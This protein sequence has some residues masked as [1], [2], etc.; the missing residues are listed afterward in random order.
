MINSKE[1]D[2]KIAVTSQNRKTITEHAG[3]CRKFWIYEINSG[4][5]AGKTLLE[6]AMADS[7]HA[8]QHQLA[9][10]LADIKVLI[11]AGMGIGLYQRLSQE[12]ILPLITQKASPDEAVV[13]YLAGN[14]ECMPVE[15]AST[16][17]G[18][19]Q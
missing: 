13:A 1:D 12:G 14:L 19:Q 17:Y 16:R 4:F 9:K 11:T 15:H 18:R 6:L 3:K 2:M 5:V 8:N 10:S 7:F